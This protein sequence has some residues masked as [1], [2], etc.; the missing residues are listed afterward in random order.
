[1]EL[2]GEGNLAERLN[3]GPLPFWEVIQLSVQLADA[4]RACLRFDIIHGDIKP[5][6]VLLTE[7]GAVKLS[8][9]GLASRLSQLSEATQAIAGTP[10]YLAPELATGQSPDAR[11]DMYS[12]G[13][14]LFEITFGRLPYSFSG[15]SVGE[16]LAAHQIAPIEFPEPWPPSVPDAWRS[17]LARL[18]SQVARRTLFRLRRADPR[19]E[20]TAARI[21]AHG[22]PRTTRFRLVVGSRFDDRR[23]ILFDGGFDRDDCCCS[24]PRSRA[25]S[26]SRRRQ[27]PRWP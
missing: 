1:M 13:V 9:F 14:T 20:K 5:S 21:T 27:A 24:R 23:A 18:V 7:S 19:P 22:R 6:N 3:D 11:S 8:D 26:Q 15:S 16:R 12:L 25:S 10:D 4:L 17:V 2:V